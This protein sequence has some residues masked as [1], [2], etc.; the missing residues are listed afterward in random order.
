[1]T[2]P[3]SCCGCPFAEVRRL[4]IFVVLLASGVLGLDIV[5]LSFVLLLS[6]GNVVASPLFCHNFVLSR[7]LPVVPEVAFQ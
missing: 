2:L 7:S 5:V 4:S 3:I 6:N 1:M